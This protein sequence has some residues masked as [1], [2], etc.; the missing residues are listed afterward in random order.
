MFV[1]DTETV[2]QLEADTHAVIDALV[3]A[4]IHIFNAIAHE[5][6][7]NGFKRILTHR[8]F[9]ARKV[10]NTPRITGEVIIY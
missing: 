8:D 2:I 6:R 1:I 10:L 3:V 4:T 5:V 9:V 7:L